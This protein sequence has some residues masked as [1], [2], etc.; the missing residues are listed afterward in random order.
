MAKLYDMNLKADTAIIA[1]E[2][3]VEN[4]FLEAFCR[5]RLAYLYYSRAD[6]TKSINE[7]NIIFRKHLSEGKYTYLSLI[8]VYEMSGQYIQADSTLNACRTMLT[9]QEYRETSERIK[10]AMW[11]TK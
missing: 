2:K 8:R 10:A 4:N 7:F 6:F 3:A 11:K 5:N 1:Y 9:E